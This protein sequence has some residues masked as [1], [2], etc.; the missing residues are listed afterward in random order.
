MRALDASG[1]SAASCDGSSDHALPKEVS[2]C[3][4]FD[5]PSRTKGL[6]PR[7]FNSCQES[8]SHHGASHPHQ[9]LHLAE[10]SRDGHLF[11][12]LHPGVHFISSSPFELLKKKAKWEWGKDQETA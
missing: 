1:P 11:F 4:H 3:L 2:F 9:C 8:Q 5:P 12:P 10:F 7:A 6:L